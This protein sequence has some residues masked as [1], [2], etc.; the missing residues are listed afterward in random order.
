M[1]VT[2]LNMCIEN[3]VGKRQALENA[4]RAEIEELDEDQVEARE[5]LLLQYGDAWRNHQINPGISSVKQWL[6]QKIQSGDS[7][8]DTAEGHM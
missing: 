6:N 3:L 5:R 2:E 8:G 7:T 4:I 1:L